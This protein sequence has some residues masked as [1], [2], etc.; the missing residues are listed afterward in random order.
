VIRDDDDDDIIIIII[1]VI[2]NDEPEGQFLALAY[3]IFPVSW[4]EKGHEK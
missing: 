2:I 4:C 3:Y 1:I